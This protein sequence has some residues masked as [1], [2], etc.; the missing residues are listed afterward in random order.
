MASYSYLID[1]EVDKFEEQ[2]F[3]RK[4]YIE[5][6]IM[7]I[8]ERADL[9]DAYAR[10]IQKISNNF[11]ILMEKGSITNPVSAIKS[12]HAIKAEQAKTLADYLRSDVLQPLRDT[13]RLRTA[14]SKTVLGDTK[15]TDITLKQILSKLE[16]SKSRVI[17]VSKDIDDATSLKDYLETIQSKDSALEER[18][19]KNATRLQNLSQDKDESEK[20]VKLVVEEFNGFKDTFTN[21]CNQLREFFKE[22]DSERLNGIK[23]AI[24]KSVVYEISFIRNLQ[25]DLDKLVPKMSEVQFEKDIAEFALF[26]PKPNIPTMNFEDFKELLKKNVKVVK[27]S[28]QIVFEKTEI[29][30]NLGLTT[31]WK[32][33]MDLFTSKEDKKKEEEKAKAFLD[34][35]IKNL[36]EGRGFSEKDENMILKLFQ[37]E[38]YRKYF[39]LNVFLVVK[40]TDATNTSTINLINR[41][42]TLFLEECELSQDW[43]HANELFQEIRKESR[44]FAKQMTN[45]EQENK[46]LAMDSFLKSHTINKS[47][48]F[49][50][51]YAVQGISDDIPLKREEIQQQGTDAAAGPR[52]WLIDLVAKYLGEAYSYASEKDTFSPVLQNTTKAFQLTEAENTQLLAKIEEAKAANKTATNSVDAWVKTMEMKINEIGT[53][54]QDTSKKGGIIFSKAKSEKI[55]EKSVEGAKPAEKVADIVKP[56]ETTIENK[57]NVNNS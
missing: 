47:A 26:A 8:Q 21:Q 29:A 37:D 31:A 52:Q 18:K 57:E 32:S 38:Y 24:M 16:Q 22:F 4:K 14:E 49:W 39:V 51:L 1:G 28:A 7:N 35:V 46:Y 33:F 36:R 41:I 54:K 5:E 45:L 30:E 50:E 55:P 44:A 34:Q 13:L 43:T 12:Y 53:V 11:S 17:K 15:R 20:Q 27:N 9:E 40:L 19:Q 2:F 48:K 23:D 42:L 10:G 6:F 25:Y 3:F 56:V